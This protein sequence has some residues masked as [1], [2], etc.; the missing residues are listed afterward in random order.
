MKLLLCFLTVIFEVG[1][2]DAQSLSIFDV[3]TSSFPVMKAKFF[4]LDRPGNS[5]KNL[6][7][8]DFVLT[9]CGI[10]REIVS[11]T[12][13]DETV[14][15]NISIALVAD[16][17]AQLSPSIDLMKYTAKEIIN[18]LPAGRFEAAI[19]SFD[20]KGTLI[21]E[22]T[23]GKNLLINALKDMSITGSLGKDYN[24]ALIDP[25]AGGIFV[26]SNA[27]YRKN[28]ILIA[29]GVPTIPID[30]TLIL[31]KARKSGVTINCIFIGSAIHETIK[32]I[33]NQTGGCYTDNVNTYD[34]AI[35]AARQI[36][37]RL[38][39]LGQASQIQWRSDF[40]C[41]RENIEVKAYAKPDL[42]SQFSY[43]LPN[44]GVTKL[45][46]CPAYITFKDL[47]VG[48]KHEMPVLITAI[49]SDFHISNFN[50]SNPRFSILET[51][52]TIRKGETKTMT[53]SYD[54]MD[55]S[56]NYSVL[57]VKT[58]KCDGEF[59]AL[60]EYE[61]A[62]E[63]DSSSG[64]K[65]TFPNGGEFFALGA[66]TTITWTGIDPAEIV[67]IEYSFDDG[68]TWNLITDNASGL[69]YLWKNIP[70]PS[71][72]RCLIRISD[73]S[74]ERSNW[75][76][77]YGGSSGE[78]FSHITRTKDGNY[79]AAGLSESND[80]DVKSNK[81][82]TDVWA[83]LINPKGDI[84]WSKSIGGQFVEGIN[85]AIEM[86][87]GSFILVGYTHSPDGDFEPVLKGWRDGLIIK[88]S[89]DGDLEWTKTLGSSEFDYFRSVCKT[90]DGGFAIAGYAGSNDFDLLGKAQGG[91]WALRFD[92]NGS[93]IWQNTYGKKIG[94]S[95]SRT[96]FPTGDG[97]FLIGG[98]SINRL[99]LDLV[100]KQKE[101]CWIAKITGDGV[102][103]P[104]WTFGGSENEQT[105]RAIET[106]DGGYMFCG[107]TTSKNGDIVNAHDED[108]GWIVK[109]GKNGDLLWQKALGGSLMDQILS[110]DE[111]ADG[112]CIGV[113]L[114]RST[115]GDIN[116]P[117]LQVR[118]RFWAVKL[119]YAG[120]VEWSLPLDDFYA[121][122]GCSV[123]A[124]EDGGFIAAGQATIKNNTY[125]QA[126]IVKFRKD[127]GN[128]S[129]VS[130]NTFS[131]LG[132]SALCDNVDMGKV[133]LGAS[134][135]SVITYFIRNSGKFAC[136]VKDISIKGEDPDDFDVNS[137]KAF[138]I[139]SGEFQ[140]VEFHFEPTAAGKRNADIEI[141]FQDSILLRSI[142]GEGVISEIKS[143]AKVID[144]GNVRIGNA[145][146]TLIA[147]IENLSA[148]PIDFTET[149]LLGQDSVQFEI[150]E[151]GGPF[152]LGTG[153]RR[154]LK[155]RFRPNYL[156]GSGCELGFFF[157][158]PLSPMLIRLLG[159]GIGG[160]IRCDHVSAAVGENAKVNLTMAGAIF[161]PMAR[162]L[163]AFRAKLRYQRT[164]L[165]PKD[166]ALLKMIE[167]DSATVEITGSAGPDSVLAS[168]DFKAGL[169]SVEFTPIELIEFIWL[170]EN[171][172]E[173]DYETLT[174][175]GSFNLLGV[176]R[177]GGDR[178]INPSPKAGITGLSPN[179][180]SLEITVT[181]NQIEAG[182][183]GLIIYNILGEEVARTMIDGRPT[184]LKEIKL[185]LSNF[186]RGMY[187]LK[188]TSPTGSDVRCFMVE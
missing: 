61:S 34:E 125:P 42:K 24:A 175:D 104:L 144:F 65:V 124:L 118:E 79:L 20:E 13:F 1:L 162:L 57:S 28:V 43:L 62:R 129:D 136:N 127:Q 16:I 102:M 150:I 96:I 56:Q 121:S 133:I 98:Q 38:T 115:D 54:A 41:K 30:E 84:I 93:L 109:V 52:T 178:L 60:A 177:E 141:V 108:E 77:L 137:K 47:P 4:A 68:M 66:D 128:Q 174:D 35:V 26:C 82:E 71:S 6:V 11:I 88:L 171:G 80:G 95:D 50:S 29:R 154:E 158:A 172:R 2:A 184:G 92:N 167:G 103:G 134:K 90:N 166:K 89:K 165:A 72:D 7:A 44:S 36:V 112:G 138:S 99:G 145:K 78:I 32:R 135:D 157:N 63:F 100:P 64:L 75:A 39:K 67:T 113:G 58:D 70:K 33:V 107:N 69:S 168:I 12:N 119:D 123:I 46:F 155:L 14:P 170:D 27:K 19:T 86:D 55:S 85:S 161:N 132:T 120:K 126:M 163:P 106:K 153:G 40:L 59:Y 76:R 187:Y 74:S 152:S 183:T 23:S 21:Q 10:P 91:V 164:L 148:L 8:S 110:I 73:K 146:D 122:R 17:S 186:S 160:R 3:D 143:M 53:V 188:F 22:L 97:Q 149:K 156:G 111:T 101:D 116:R 87:D 25:A 147:L 81:G 105:E 179:P 169:G 31:D 159:R 18:T 185:N 83:I 94:T 142:T 9:E 140:A 151:G 45:V 173:I 37:L 117:D 130:D 131:I 49:N 176:C 5:I 139:A 181:I 48:A 182:E 180:A 114:T 51:G 15:E